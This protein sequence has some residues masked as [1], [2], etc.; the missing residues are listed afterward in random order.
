ML[1]PL[2]M[3]ESVFESTSD[4]AIALPFQRIT[5]PLVKFVPV[6]FIFT[7]CEPATMV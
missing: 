4:V 5:D 6:I 1:L 7:L 3:L 2:T